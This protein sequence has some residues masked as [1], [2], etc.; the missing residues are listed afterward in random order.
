MKHHVNL[1]VDA[2]LSELGARQH[3]VF[4]ADQAGRRGVSYDALK[5]RRRI[6]RIIRLKRGIYRLRDH[7]WT[8]EAQ[9]Q[10]GLVDAGPGAVISHRS[11]AQLHEFW[12]YRSHCAVEVSGPDHHDHMVTLAR[13]HRS[14]L[15]PAN[16]RTVKAGFPVTTVA[17]TCF[18]LIGDPDPAFRRSVEGRGVHALHMT[19][20]L[21]D[22]LGRRGLLLGQLAAVRASIGKRGRPG[23]ALTGEL[24]LKLGPK[25]TP[26]DSEGESLVMELI[27]EWTLPSPDRQVSMSD[28]E[29]WIGT[30]D[31]V[32]PNIR[33]V[34]EI[35]GNW[36][37]GPCDQEADAARD[38]RVRRLGYEVWRWPYRDLVVAAPR[39][40]RD[41]A[42][43]L[44]LRGETGA[45]A[46]VSI[47]HSPS[48]GGDPVR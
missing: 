9:M 20:V 25:Y 1:D 15:I 45:M 3:G 24:L 23:S 31:F 41:L 19:R 22:A 18:D 4:H 37:D 17:R 30:V 47:Q 34:L 48:D 33:L 14:A 16:H 46:P 32:W 5:H 21:N 44:E 2:I 36:H 6:G 13:F 12:R 8:W 7:P 28:D 27:D 40:I 26:T 38:A 39:L 10:A 29:G 35:D 43:R 42:Q 11:A